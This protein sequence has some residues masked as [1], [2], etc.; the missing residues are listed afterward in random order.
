M[1][2]VKAVPEGYH[3]VTAQIAVEGCAEALEFWQ[4]AFGAEVKDKMP[5][6]SGQKIWHASMRV[7]DSM[8]MANDVMHEMGGKAWPTQLWLYVDNVDAAFKRAVD[9]GATV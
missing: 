6:P 8:I 4:K 7:G 1:S 2:K 5:D 9:A 3:T